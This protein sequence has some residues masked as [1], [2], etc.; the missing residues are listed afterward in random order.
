MPAA[1]PTAPRW[2]PR[3]LVPALPLL[4][5]G[6][7]AADRAATNQ[8]DWLRVPDAQAYAWIAVASL[9]LLLRRRAP[10][11]TVVVVAAAL[12]A[13]LAQG[14][15]FGPVLFTGPAAAWAVAVARPWREALTWIAGLVLVTAAA[16]SVPFYD[17]G[18]GWVAH[19]GWVGAWAAAVGAS[20]SCSAS[21]QAFS[22]HSTSSCIS[23]V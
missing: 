18:A 17:G 10:R 22:R 8:P 13:Y 19:L 4:V 16:V 14:F 23:P 6:L 2:D 21:R 9:A 3:E 7:A 1:A 5:I 11:L 12:S 20:V 15:A